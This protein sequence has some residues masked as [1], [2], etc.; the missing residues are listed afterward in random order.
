M[1]DNYPQDWDEIKRVL[2]ERYNQSCANCE[3]SSTPLEA[4]HIVPVSSGGSHKL[5]NLVP[6]CPKCHSAV[7]NDE[8]APAVRWYTNGDLSA[9]EFGEHKRFWKKLR[10]K[11]GVPRYDS[12]EDCVY[13]PLA[14]TD[15]IIDSDFP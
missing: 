8:L 15:L 4:H 9:D 13:I 14:D 5:D 11:H 12:S 6:L 7:H 3:R 2:F 10:D 1:S